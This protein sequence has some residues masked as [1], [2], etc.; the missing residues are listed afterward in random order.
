M[1]RVSCS[2]CSPFY[3]FGA[4]FRCFHNSLIRYSNY[5]ADVYESFVETVGRYLLLEVTNEN[6]QE[7]P[8]N[9][10]WICSVFARQ[11][12]KWGKALPTSVIGVKKC[13]KRLEESPK[14]CATAYSCLNENARRSRRWVHLLH[15]FQVSLEISD[16][17]MRHLL[18]RR[19][20]V[21][22]TVAYTLQLDLSHGRNWHM[23]WCAQLSMFSQMERI[24]RIRRRKK[25]PKRTRK[26]ESLFAVFLSI[27]R[28]K[29]SRCIEL[30]HW[31]QI[32]VRLRRLPAGVGRRGTMCSEIQQRYRWRPI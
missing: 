29:R 24:C 25:D 1:G 31:L 28:R 6:Q 13:T 16:H 5:S 19:S 3:A 4:S 27:P 18:N 7:V 2:S 11:L 32:R 14:S 10:S 23:K 20:S 26:S 30:S 9:F 22:Q 8:D 17:A 12:L 21:H 15:R